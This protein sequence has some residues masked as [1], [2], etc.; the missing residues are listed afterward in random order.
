MAGVPNAR[1]KQDFRGQALAF[2]ELFHRG[3]VSVATAGN[4][5]LQL[6]CECSPKETQ[7]VDVHTAVPTLER[8]CCAKEQ[9]P[10]ELVPRCGAQQEQPPLVEGCCCSAEL[11]PPQLEHTP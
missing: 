1:P 2:S 7:L 5:H 9:P 6:D 11:V 8:G 4:A 10:T 3:E